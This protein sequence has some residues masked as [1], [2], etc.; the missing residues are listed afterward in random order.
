M[1]KTFSK[2]TAAALSLILVLLMTITAGAAQLQ[3]EGTKASPF[4]ISNA[5]ELDLLSQL[6]ADGESF[7]GKYFVLSDSVTANEGFTPIGTAE[8]PF[9]GIFDGNRNTLSGFNTECDYAAVFAFTDGAVIKD[10]TVSG[11]FFATDYAG[12]VVAF[13]SNTVIEGCT[14]SAIVYADNF[15]GGIAGCITSGRINNC[16][17]SSS[18]MTGGY[19]VYCGGI[20]GKS[21]ADITN[22]T[23]GAYTYGTKNVGGI[24]GESSALISSCTNTAT[25]S[26]SGENLGGIAGITTG[27][28]TLSR[29]TGSVS[30]YFNA[31]ISKAGG[32]AGVGYEAEISECRNS[33][34]VSATENF[35][36]GIAGYLTSGSVSDCLS[37]TSVSAGTDFAGGIFG[38]ALK[39]QVSDCVFAGTATAGNG[40]AAGIGALAQCTTADCYYNSDRNDTAVFTGTATGCTGVTS[41]AFSSEASFGG[42]DFED[43]WTI[44]VNH[45]AYPLLKGIPYHN[46]QVLGNTPAD[47]TNDGIVT[48]VCSVCQEETE[49]ITP[50]TGHS[51]IV[52]SSKLASCTVSGY[53]DTLCTVCG[54]TETEVLTAPGHTDAD[55]NSKCDVCSATIK[56]DDN[57]QQGE[58]TIFEKIADFFRSLIE[59]VRNFFA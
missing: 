12:A 41:A 44:N 23:N 47:C 14:D 50:A 37:T 6:V 9:S 18:A 58:K 49:T 48:G 34:N 32:I 35:A 7:S 4:I 55:G 1:K 59:W 28:I 22:C 3:G 54:D 53:K 39:A 20:A 51:Y 24:A 30:A 27:K 17:T 16:T 21:G 29:N 26:A 36:G 5:D 52:V 19:E 13:A 42:L 38:Y 56:T 2:I 40:S 45:G 8:T 46:I 11:S 57:T 15:S 33:G 43:T 25:V 31:P 10:L